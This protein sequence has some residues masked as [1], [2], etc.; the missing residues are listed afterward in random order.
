[1][2]QIN[3]KDFKYNASTISTD[4]PFKSLYASKLETGENNIGTK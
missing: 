3:A 4:T 2:G 1:M